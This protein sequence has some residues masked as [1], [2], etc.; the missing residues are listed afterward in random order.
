MVTVADDIPEKLR[1]AAS[2]ALKWVNEERGAAFKLTGVVDADAALAAPADDAVEF[3]LVLCEDEVCLREQVRVERQDGR[4][5]VSAVE[6]PS[7]L[8]PPLLD[9]PRGVR[10]DW[11]DGQLSTREFAVLLVYRGL[12]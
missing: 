5:Q 8:I 6:A 3:G 7:S 4:F 2:A 1:P 11:L 12:W 9:P 10:R